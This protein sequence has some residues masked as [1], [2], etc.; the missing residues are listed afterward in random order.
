MKRLNQLLVTAGM[1]VALTLSACT[2]APQAPATAAATPPSATVSPATTALATTQPAAAAATDTLPTPTS[3]PESLFA[4]PAGS[5]GA[6]IP[7][8]EYEAEAAS[9]NGTVL[10]AS[11][12]FGEVAAESSGRT[13][14][15]LASTG[16]YV[17]FTTT[18]AANSI[19]VRYVIPDADAGGGITATL[20]LY[21]NDILRQPLTLTSRYAW[22]YGGETQTAN[23]PGL[24]GEH[25]FFDEAR[26]LVGDIPAGATVK[27][28][29]DNGDT[30]AYYVVDLIDLE[31]VAQPGI[32]PANYLAISDCGAIPDDGVDDTR[33]IQQCVELASSR[34]QGVWIPQGTY[35][36]TATLGDRMGIV[37]SNIAIRGAGMWYST[38]HGPSARF[39]CIGNGCR[40]YNFAILGETTMRDDQVPENGFN[41][42]GGTGSRLENVWVE[43]TK[44]GWWVGEGNRN[45]T[46][47]LV[48]TGSRFRNLFADGV[49][50]C[51]GTSNSTVEN[52]HFRNTGD[53][54]LASWTPAQD[55][56]VNT[57]NVFRFNTVQLPWRANCFAVYGGKDIRIEDSVCA[58][59]VTY[60]GILIAQDFDAHPFAGTTTVQ[61]VSLIRAG[62]PMWGQKHGALKVLAVKGPINGLLVKDLLIES[63]TFTGIQLQGPFELDAASFEQIKIAN[64]GSAGISITTARGGATFTAVTVAPEG[65]RGLSDLST[66]GMFNI[67][68]G[69]GNRGW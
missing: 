50:F 65:S 29:K 16:Q 52:T 1:L 54:A 9:T 26:A 53:D 40:F 23:D 10:D 47:G 17:Q 12:A 3:E 27:L 32:M 13:S 19:V 33:A 48:V 18:Q 61:R 46:D 15:K 41:G 68:R 35:E 22:S 39:H 6:A 51:N 49:N 37:V 30:A 4:P 8:V 43:H 42:G 57:N 60:P 25:H 62:G 14:V 59:V 21:V 58:D 66:S 28:Q 7:W 56:G 20:S 69:E 64:A 38:L 55:R 34:D 44:V 24:G 67:T 63:P 2:S 5:R 31:Q 36:T 11:R 45:V